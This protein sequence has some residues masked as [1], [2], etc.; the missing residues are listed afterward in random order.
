MKKPI[1]KAN[2]LLALIVFVASCTERID[3]DLD[4]QEYARIVVEGAISTD[5]MAHMITIT[6]TADY[7]DNLPPAPVTNANV[8]VYNDFEEYQLTEKPENSGRYF[9]GSDVYGTVGREYEMKITLAEEVGGTTEYHASS[10]IY[11]INQLDSIALEF[12][13]DWGNEGFWEV[14]CYVWDPPTTD[15]YMFYVYRNGAPCNDTITEVFVVD[16]IL[17]NG[18]Y[19]NGIGV[20]FLDQSADHQKLEPGDVVTLRVSRITEDY[21]NFLWEVQEEV[22]FSTPLFSGPPANVKGNIDN[23]GFGAFAAYSNSYA[24]TV[25]K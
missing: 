11:P 14:K 1:L 8:S 18:N 19:T 12:H 13:E 23:G 2:I 3:I 20:A 10:S 7:F 21:T 9:T 25:V 6:K 15:F 4:Q 17:Y 22:S 16:D 24:S 5:T